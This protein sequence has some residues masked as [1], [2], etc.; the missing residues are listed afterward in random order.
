M[1]V[2]VWCAE[3]SGASN[4]TMSL[5]SVDA[6]V[7]DSYTVL[8]AVVYYSIEVSRQKMMGEVVR[9]VVAEPKSQR[10]S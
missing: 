5:S 10:T 6:V 2:V 4:T 9:N 3:R 8:S 7:G 1:V